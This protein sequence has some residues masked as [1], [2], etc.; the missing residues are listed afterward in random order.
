M[1]AKTSAGTTL[2]IS[3][4]APATF[5]Q[6]GFEALSFTEIGEITNIDG[7]IGRTYNTVSHNPLASRATQ[8]LKGSY[9]SGSV[10]AQYAIDR[11]DAGQALVDAALISD[12]PYSFELTEQDGTKIYFRGLVMGNP[13]TPGSTDTVTG[14][15]I[16][17]E[18]TAEDDG[19][20]FVIVEA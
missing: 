6:A 1:T 7:Q 16:S 9:N 3:A 13:V 12:A 5:N 11:D 17:I 4:S 15:S 19:D 18:I 20:D 10:S 8:K 2:A 14:G